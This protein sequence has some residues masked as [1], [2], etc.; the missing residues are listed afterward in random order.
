MEASKEEGIDAHY[1]WHPSFYL[2]GFRYFGSP[3]C[4]PE[5]RRVV[6]LSTQLAIFPLF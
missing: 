5:K 4:S 3:G 1:S 2:W 6:R